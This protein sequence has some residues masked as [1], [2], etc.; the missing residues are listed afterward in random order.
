MVIVRGTAEDMGTPAQVPE[1]LAA[2]SAKYASEADW[3]YLPDA[4]PSFDIVY[5]IRP[6]SAMIW[7]LA[8]YEG[9]QRRWTS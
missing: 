2:L 1:V 6:H 5:A 4:D 7:R 8:D 3:Q 9:S